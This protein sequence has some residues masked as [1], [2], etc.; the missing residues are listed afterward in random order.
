LI[1]KKG[2]GP[3]DEGYEVRERPSSTREGGQNPQCSTINARCD[4]RVL[5][6]ERRGGQVGFHVEVP[7][8]HSG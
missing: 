6:R 8:N 4:K 2:G 7:R 3:G 5:G 1:N